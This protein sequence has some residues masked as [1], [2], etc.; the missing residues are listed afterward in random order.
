MSNTNLDDKLIKPSKKE[1]Q[2]IT[3]Q[4][5]SSIFM[6]EALILEKIPAVSLESSGKDGLRP[7]MVFRCADCGTI[8]EELNMLKGITIKK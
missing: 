7:M 3:C 4:N 2:V 8:P 5:C 6:E 1:I